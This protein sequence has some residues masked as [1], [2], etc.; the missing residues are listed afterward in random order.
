MSRCAVE[1]TSKPDKE[2]H[3]AHKEQVEVTVID[4]PSEHRFEG[5]VDG[6]LVGFVVYESQPEGLV[7]VHTEVDD[8]FEGQGVGSALAAGV[9]DEI[10]RRGI[11]IVARCPFVSR[12]ISRHPEYG[13]LVAPTG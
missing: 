8:E 11:V 12:Y 7:L 5:Y 13:D 3:V 10:R 2:P 1:S 6:T 4:N 9:L